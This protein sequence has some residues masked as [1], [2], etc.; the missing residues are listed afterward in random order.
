MSI[1][2]QGFSDSDFQEYPNLESLQIKLRLLKNI[3]FTNKS[4]KEIS[5]I[6]N[7]HLGLI[8]TLNGTYSIE[9][10]NKFQFY[11]VRANVNT[12]TEDLN[13]IQTYSFPSPQFCTVNGRSNLKHMS[14]FYC[15]NHALTALIE[16]KPKV[17]EVGYLSFWEGNTTRDMKAGILLPKTLKKENMW[18]ELS[19]D[20][21]MYVESQVNQHLKEKGL[22]FHEKLNFVAN[23][24]LSELPPYPITSLISYEMLYGKSPKDFIVYPSFANNS[25]SC[26]MAIHPNV[27]TNFMRFK[28]VIRFKVTEINGQKFSISTGRVGELVNNNMKWRTATLEELDFSLFPL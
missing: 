27:V 8:P 4:Y 19:D 22:L 23:L 11:R 15:S 2:T 1:P 3:D 10:F 18:H 25:Y 16:S 21:Y 6:I 5:E 20:L 13:L 26:N 24:F 28:K 17:G 7:S 12:E 14:V 9:K